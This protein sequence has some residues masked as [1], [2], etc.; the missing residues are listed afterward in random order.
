[1]ESIQRA[2]VEKMIQLVVEEQYIQFKQAASE[3]LDQYD[4][5]ALVSIALKLL[6]KEQS[7]VPVQLTSETPRYANKPKMKVQDK[8]R[9]NYKGNREFG[10]KG[11]RKKTPK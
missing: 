6:S 5:I 7:D 3:L 2:A 8:P 4:S 1:M 10:K 9:R 11:K